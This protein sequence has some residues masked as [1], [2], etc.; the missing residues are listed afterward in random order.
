MDTIIA[1][2]VKK[3]FLLRSSRY[4]NVVATPHMVRLQTLYEP[5]SEERFKAQ[6]VPMAVLLEGTFESA[7]KNR[8]A[9]KAK[10]DEMQG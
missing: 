1:K 8:I 4:S 5:P 7:F 3:T 2:G 10:G 6:G 9:P